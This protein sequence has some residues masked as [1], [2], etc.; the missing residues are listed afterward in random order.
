MFEVSRNKVPTQI[1][2]AGA[3]AEETSS[4]VHICLH[5]AALGGASTPPLGIEDRRKSSS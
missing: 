5:E 2:E 3:Q 1:K 4:C